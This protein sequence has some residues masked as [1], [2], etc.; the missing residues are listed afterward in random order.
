MSNELIIKV[1][2]N[3][4]NGMVISELNLDGSN[5]TIDW[6][7]STIDDYSESIKHDYDEEGEYT[8][9][10]TGVSGIL[11]GLLYGIRN[12]VEVIIPNNITSLPHNV[13]RECSNLEKVV[14]P[15]GISSIG[16]H[17]CRA[18][19]NLVELN[20]PDGLEDIGIFFLY[21]CGLDEVIFPYGLSVI[22]RNALD[23][24]NVSNIVIPKSVTRIGDYAFQRCANLSYIEIP[25][26]IDSIGTFFCRNSS[27]TTAKFYS[28][29][30][31]TVGTYF[32][33]GND[34]CSIHIPE[35]SLENYLNQ[36]GFPTESSRYVEYPTLKH[37]LETL[38]KL[39]ASNL[40]KQF[41][42]AS[43]D[44][45]LTTL[46]NKIQDI[47]LNN[48]TGFIA[49]IGFYDQDSWSGT[50]PTILKDKIIFNGNAEFPFNNVVFPDT[51]T[52]SF[53]LT[54]HDKGDELTEPIT[55]GQSHSL[56]FE[57]SVDM[58]FCIRITRENG[59]AFII[60]CD[61]TDD[62]IPF[63][64]LS[65]KSLLITPYGA[66][67]VTISGIYFSEEY[68]D[69]PYS[70]ISY[71]LCWD[72]LFHT[73]STD[74]WDNDSDTKPTSVPLLLLKNGTPFK[75][76]SLTEATDDLIFRGISLV[77]VNYMNHC[78]GNY[79][80]IFSSD[81]SNYS[82]KTI[83]DIGCQLEFE[84]NREDLY[85][86]IKH[87]K[88]GIIVDE[89]SRLDNYFH[90]LIARGYDEVNLQDY[91]ILPWDSSEHFDYQIVCKTPTGL[92]SPKLFFTFEYIRLDETNNDVGI[93]IDYTGY[94]GQGSLLFYISNDMFNI[95]YNDNDVYSSEELV[96]QDYNIITIR[97]TL[98]GN[99]TLIWDIELNGNSV[100]SY[101]SDIKL[102]YSYSYAF[103]RQG[104]QNNA[105]ISNFYYGSLEGV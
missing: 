43:W 34:N 17:F 103:I 87:V 1:E 45:G 75:S 82:W 100:L 3:P 21:E 30:P 10:I 57:E 42:S 67:P 16:D 19:T 38:G 58:E 41:V 24:S 84:D 50:P 20:L 90:T 37:K 102:G 63:N 86:P 28:E 92:S 69:N 4:S 93:F 8:I 79:H 83:K 12:V 11:N 35:G 62:E 80:Y 2:A 104:Y 48:M 5:I 26:S 94:T 18:C 22:N 71:N 77:P 23:S 15:N 31:P 13:F 64:S 40:T 29:T 49:D 99:S 70:K 61:E 97:Q 78:W 32:L 60:K 54:T 91:D 39:M 88:K 85:F 56:N 95:S 72:N 105:K 27:L 6:G 74:I 68:D 76:Y 55:I 96:F 52:W 101:T 33:E 59:G 51:F 81:M 53:I 7:D 25:N 73:K 9:T 89:S 14:L 98:S 46:A 66:N 44:E 47:E 65:F 36:Q